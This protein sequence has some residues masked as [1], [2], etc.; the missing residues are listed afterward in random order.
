MKRLILI[1]LALLPFSC[2]GSK[3]RLLL[4]HSTLVHGFEGFPPQ[5]LEGIVYA[6]AAYDE[7]H[8]KTF[9]HDL[10]RKGIIPVRLNMQLRGV[11]QENAQILI[12]PG[13]M[14]ARLYLIDGTPLGQVR[15]DDVADRLGERPARLVREHAFQGGLLGSQP[16]TGY[17]FF[18]LEPL[19]EFKSKGRNL[20]HTQEGV[21]H[22]FD[23]AHSLLAFEVA[24]QNSSQEIYVGIQR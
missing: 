19:E 5:A 2:L 6:Q 20:T 22:R 23:L 8:A 17:L 21:A 13:R 18:A 12:K 11:G 14:N 9:R 1:T 24:I 3:P 16:T 7:D 4:D 15:A 10:M